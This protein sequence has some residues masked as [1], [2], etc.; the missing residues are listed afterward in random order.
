MAL[1]G[2]AAPVKPLA[3]VIIS[4]QTLN[5]FAAKE[6]P[7]LPKPVITSSK[8]SKIPCLS[9]ISLMRSKYPSGGTMTPPE[10]ITGSMMTPAI[11]DAS[12]RV[13]IDSNSSAKCRP[14]VGCPLENDISFG[15]HVCGRWSV[16]DS[17]AP[18]DFLLVGMPPTEVPPTLTP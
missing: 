2:I 5:L 1:I 3:I 13:S 18:K 10:P 15:S 4:G 6:L 17:S 7:N 9:H 8:I 14:Q 16:P 11:V 12:C